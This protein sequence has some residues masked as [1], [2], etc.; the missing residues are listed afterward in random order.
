MTTN[1]T[2]TTADQRWGFPFGVDGFMTTAEACQFLK[3]SPRVIHDLI[4]RGDIRR[5]GRTKG[6]RLCKRSVHVYARSLET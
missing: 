3:K 1:A 2:P 6:V 4:K 5:G